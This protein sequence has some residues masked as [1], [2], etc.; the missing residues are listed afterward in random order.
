M[1]SASL[2]RCEMTKTQLDWLVSVSDSIR[3]DSRPAKATM[4]SIRSPAYTQ[5][6]MHVRLRLLSE[7]PSSMQAEL[8]AMR[9]ALRTAR[10]QGT[11][12]P[13]RNP[14]PWHF[15]WM[16]STLHAI[17]FDSG[18][19][20]LFRRAFVNTWLPCH[21]H[22]PLTHCRHC[23]LGFRRCMDLCRHAKALAT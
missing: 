15:S 17:N 18:F 4:S 21:A 5:M 14:G 20:F 19:S 13:W 3:A 12:S 7:L 10:R 1:H 8:T 6:F 23:L 2:T 16:R 11:L 9:I 22:E